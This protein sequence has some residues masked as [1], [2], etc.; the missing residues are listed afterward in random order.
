M[1]TKNKFALLVGWE[2]RSW[3]RHFKQ[4]LI[5]SSF[6]WLIEKA[7]CLCSFCTKNY[8]TN[9]Y[10]LKINFFALSNTKQQ[11]SSI[12]LK[13]LGKHSWTTWAPRPRMCV[14]FQCWCHYMKICWIFLHKMCTLAF[15]I[16]RNIK[17]ENKISFLQAV[18]LPTFVI[19][20]TKT[21]K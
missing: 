19:K 21:R 3:C 12:I 10:I 13:K 8:I 9:K 20:G 16:V 17:S 11:K 15:I 5:I 6:S 7:L 18:W 14:V 4:A 1:W 2:H